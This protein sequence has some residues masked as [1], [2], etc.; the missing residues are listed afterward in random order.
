MGS[1]GQEK[2]KMLNNP[3]HLVLM[4]PHPSPLSA[5]AV[6]LDADFLVRQMNFLKITV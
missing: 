2:K 4:A 5:F 6:F 1:T 3:E